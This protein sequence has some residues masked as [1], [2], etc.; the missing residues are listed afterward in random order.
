MRK[1]TRMMDF[2]DHGASSENAEGEQEAQCYWA[3]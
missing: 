1:A 2:E 3:R